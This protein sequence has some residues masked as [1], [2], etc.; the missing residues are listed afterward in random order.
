MSTPPSKTGRPRK[1]REKFRQINVYLPPQMLA[2]L[3][4]QIAREMHRTGYLRSRAAVIRSL[5]A[6]YLQAPDTAQPRRTPP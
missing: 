5:I 3:D 1:G 4:R 6:A 2:D